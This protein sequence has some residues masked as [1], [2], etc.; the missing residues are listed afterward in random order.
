M[1]LALSLPGCAT[2]AAAADRPPPPAFAG[3]E[4]PSA[5]AA[6]KVPRF[7]PQSSEENLGRRLGELAAYLR[8]LEATRRVAHE[9]YYFTPH[10]GRFCGP[11]EDFD[12][13]RTTFAM[14]SDW[15]RVDKRDLLPLF[16]RYIRECD[17]AEG[18]A[19]RAGYLLDTLYWNRLLDTTGYETRDMLTVRD[20][21][22]EI[23]INRL[24]AKSLAKNRQA[25]AEPQELQKRWEDFLA[26]PKMAR[27]DYFRLI[28]EAFNALSP[29]ERR[30]M[31]VM[32]ELIDFREGFLTP[33]GNSLMK[34]LA[35]PEDVALVRS[36]YDYLVYARYHRE[37]L[38]ERHGGWHRLMALSHGNPEQVVRVFGVMSALLYIPL[39]ELAPS[40][41]AR[42]V[43][44]AE[45]AEA[46]HN[47]SM[48][49]YLMNELDEAAAEQVDNE[50]LAYH[51]FLPDG[52]VSS[53]WKFYHYFNNAYIGCEL[54]KRGYP[55]SAILAS[56]RL[57]GTIYEG[58][59]L[60]LAIPARYTL[61]VDPRITPIIE[62]S[63]DVQLNADGA[64]FGAQICQSQ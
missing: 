44:D 11:F 25:L 29:N 24:T 16:A 8:T 35:R 41:A 14:W 31:N 55:R 61:S 28:T 58:T 33:F 7:L 13:Q 47:G 9:P 50:T 57:L 63:E 15:Q 1:A 6:A 54:K 22:Y 43:F 5:N 39:E 36:F 32:I 3:F 17:Y 46:M 37:L 59:T 51:F 38:K 20:A 60:N 42:G 18:A 40:L 53:N 2:G 56:A 64:A 10:A 27:I 26:A 62:S 34:V 21:F 23:Y 19:K 48:A 30:V 49:Y 12:M 45:K 4:G 52:Y